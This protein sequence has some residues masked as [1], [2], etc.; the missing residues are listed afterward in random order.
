MHRP[1]A[2][3]VDHVQLLGELGRH[4]VRHADRGGDDRAHDVPRLAARSPLEAKQKLLIDA[5]ASGIG[6]FPNAVRLDEL[7]GRPDPL[8]AKMPS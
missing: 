4:V 6:D 7:E 5:P 8:E 1:A 3:P 2:R